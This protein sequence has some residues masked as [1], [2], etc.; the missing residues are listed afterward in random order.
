MEIPLPQVG[1]SVV[2]GYINRW[3]VKPGQSVSKFDPLVEIVTDKVSMDFP[4]PVSGT[5]SKIL[6]PE[7]E[8][9]STGTPIIDIE[10]SESNPVEEPTNFVERQHISR[11]GKLLKNVGPVGPT[12]SGRLKNNNKHSSTF[13]SPAVLRA[14]KINHLDLT[15]I[16]GTGENGRVTLKDLNDFIS[17]TSY[18]SSESSQNVPHTIEIVKTSSIR[19]TISERM[20]KSAREI[21]HAWTMVEIDVTELINLRTSIMDS[22]FAQEGIKLTYLPFAIHSACAAM[23]E[24]PLLNSTWN[25]GEIWVNKQINIGI[26]VS[27]E[28]G[29]FVPVIPNTNKLTISQIAKQADELINRAREG[30]LNIHEVQN[31]TFTINNTGALGSVLSGPLIN[32]PQAAILT[33]ERIIQRPVVIDGTIKV[34]HIMNMCLSFDHRIMDGLEA[35]NFL[36]SVKHSLE[37]ISSDTNLN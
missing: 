23:G 10:T 19:K 7:G 11:V 21:P 25:E 31:C 13:Y 33:T 36:A 28:N 14:A 20:E 12:G 9:V 4:A 8:T 22:F 3:L 27:T 6:I 17:D 35:S 24:N 18:T 30:T 15:K 37:N 26:A 2:D 16:H 1:E 5:I 32:H 34:R 29:L